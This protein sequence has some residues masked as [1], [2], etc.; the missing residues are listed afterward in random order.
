MGRNILGIFDGGDVSEISA[1]VDKLEKSSFDY[2]KLEG[3][4]ISI[5]IGKNGVCDVSGTAFAPVAA[6]PVAAMPAAAPAPVIQAPA[7]DAQA[8][9][10][11]AKTVVAE[12]EGVFT[13]KAPSQGLF[14][15]QPEPGAP[16]YVSVG[17]RVKTGDTV[18]LI[19]I[20]KT[21]SALTSPVDGEVIAVHVVNEEYLEPDQALISIKVG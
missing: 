21:Y 1:L 5:V 9:A 8:E 2:M 20:M 6:V 12:Q 7:A 19:E 14:F 13:I 16:P 15:S 10:P 3:D 18:C 17:S 4:G 11:A